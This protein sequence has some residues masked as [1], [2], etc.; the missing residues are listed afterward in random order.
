MARVCDI[1]GDFII[2]KDDLCRVSRLLHGARTGLCRR[3][4]PSYMSD[5]H[6]CFDNFLWRPGQIFYKIHPVLGSER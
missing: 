1:S 4:W 6:R 5:V 3:G 2:A